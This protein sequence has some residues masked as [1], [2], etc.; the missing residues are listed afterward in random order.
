MLPYHVT[1][2]V[3]NR[4]AYPLPLTEVWPLFLQILFESCLIHGG[5]VHALVLMPNHFHLLITCPESDLGTLMA[6]FGTQLT[7]RHN[8]L[9]KRCG[10][11]F[12]GRYHWSLINSEVY[13]AHATR[14]VYRN[15]VRAGLVSEER[16][17]EYRFSSLPMKLGL[18]PP[19]LTLHPLNSYLLSSDPWD[20]LEWMAQP[21]P[22]EE[23]ELIRKGLKR[24]KFKLGMD[25]SSSRRKTLPA[26]T[27]KRTR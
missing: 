24:A 3:N 19:E 27:L 17:E 13:A 4:E 7:K 1:N 21:T 16:L 9:A 15:P 2:Q 6:D 22:K 18:A 25:R 5:R 11:L 26:P 14:Y 12:R 10:H 23:E 8:H 20:L